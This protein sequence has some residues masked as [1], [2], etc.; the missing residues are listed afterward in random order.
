MGQCVSQP[1]VLDQAAQEE[2]TEE[3]EVK[4]D[5]RKDELLLS[6][7]GLHGVFDGV[8]VDPKLL[9][10]QLKHFR[11]EIQKKKLAPFWPAEDEETEKSFEFCP[12]CACYYRSVN[13]T[14]C[15]QF[16]LCSECHARNVNGFLFSFKASQEN[17]NNKKGQRAKPTCVCCRKEDYK[18]SYRGVQTRKEREQIE[19][20]QKQV[21]ISLERA[22]VG[23]E[24]ETR[25]RQSLTR[26]GKGDGGEVPK[27]WEEEFRMARL[28]EEGG[29]PRA[30]EEVAE[31]SF[32]RVAWDSNGRNSSSA[33]SLTPSQR[34]S[35]LRGRSE[36]FSEMYD[37]LF[38]DDEDRGSQRSRRS[39]DLG[40]R[41][42]S[43]DFRRNS[44]EFYRRGVLPPFESAENATNAAIT[45]G[46]ARQQQQQQ[47]QHSRRL[48][49]DFRNM[50]LEELYLSEAIYRSMLD[51]HEDESE[52][53]VH[54]HQIGNLEE[55]Y[56]N[57]SETE[58]ASDVGEEA[59]NGRE[60][61]EDRE[62]VDDDD[63]DDDEDDDGGTTRD[64]S[65]EDE[66]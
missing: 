27:G 40:S 51:V 38:D 34:I 52:G 21:E 54:Q 65:S 59:P 32:G 63:N 20:E 48:V 35:L 64:A 18:V 16:K 7:R 46:N 56:E 2:E 29:S 1:L 33:S 15:C 13:V 62:E 53:E 60:N 36:M 4:I 31:R 19:K 3:T 11:V 49:Q 23:V 9:S 5:L 39:L 26:E 41:R 22:K 30:R 10:K 58:E 44:E 50:V 14:K 8:Y 28:A 6:P 61:N 12:I 42:N 43:Q 45:T 55:G 47:Q 24:E 17:N 66:A 25:R 57:N 37:A